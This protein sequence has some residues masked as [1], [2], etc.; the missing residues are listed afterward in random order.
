MKTTRATRAK[1]R[2][3]RSG[4]ASGAKGRLILA[5]D[6]G[7][8]KVEAAL[9][10]PRGK[11]VAAE[12]RA[13]VVERSAADGL[14]S[15]R[16]AADAVLV[17]APRSAVKAIGVSVP[18]WV[19]VEKGRVLQTANLPCW[20]NYPL[21]A[22]LRDIYGIPVRLENDANAAGAAEAVW[23]AGRG[24][25]RFFY[26]SL[27]TGIGTCLAYR[28]DDGWHFPASEGGHMSINFSGPLCPCG[29]R[30]CVE[31]YASGKAIAR[32]AKLRVSRGGSKAQLLRSM[33]QENLGSLKTE[34][35]A[36]AAKRGDELAREILQDACDRLAVWLGNILDILDPEAIVFGG[37]LAGVFLAHRAR[38]HKALKGGAARPGRS[39]VRIV[40]ARFGAQSALMG[41]AALWPAS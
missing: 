41:A 5:I 20:R 23:G 19:D 18:G 24:Y 9:I 21:A 39:A 12:R 30:G 38:I 40:G 11:I 35:V 10:D 13:M 3:K 34:M 37:G 4:G 16:Q 1:T 31:M 32:E 27:G 15:V 28:T 2:K 7:G 33:A 25:R 26:V 14:R 17:R 22:N 29:K 36:T 8:T 6:V